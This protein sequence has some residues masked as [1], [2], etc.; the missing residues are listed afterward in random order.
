VS[1]VDRLTWEDVDF[2][3]R[4]VVLCTRKKKGG[5]LTPTKI[6][7]TVR[8]YQVLCRRYEHKGK[9]KLWVFWHRF[10]DRKKK[11]CVESP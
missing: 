8:L 10:W 2:Q 6:P 7:M 9:R 11:G 4:S 3:D 1:E 5:H